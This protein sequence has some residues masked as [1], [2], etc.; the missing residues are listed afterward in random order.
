MK[1]ANKVEAIKAIRADH[2]ATRVELN[3]STGKYELRFGAGLREE[4]E[5]VEA[6]MALGVRE[7][8]DKANNDLII[9]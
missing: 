7:F 9:S 8:L 1:F 4:K 6:I 2:A 3:E 5:L